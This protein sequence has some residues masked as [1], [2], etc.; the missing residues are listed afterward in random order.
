M[1]YLINRK[2]FILDNIEA[3]LKAAFSPANI[4]ASLS[5]QPL[6]ELQLLLEN[7]GNTAIENLRAFRYQVPP[8]DFQRLCQQNYSDLF[9]LQDHVAAW[10]QDPLWDTLRLDAKAFYAALDKMLQAVQIFLESTGIRGMAAEELLPACYLE[11][12]LSAMA[13]NINL[14]RSRFLSAAADPALQ[15]LL[16]AHFQ[17]SCTRREVRQQELW[18]MEQLMEA[19]LAGLSTSK[20]AD[21]DLFLMHELVKWNFNSPEGYGYCRDKLMAA[22][23][24]KIGRKRRFLLMSWHLKGI[25]QLLCI[26]DQS[27]HPQYPS[28]KDLLIELLQTEIAYAET[29]FSEAE[30]KTPEARLESPT[31]FGASQSTAKFQLQL[32]QRMLA[33]WTQTLI[34]MRIITLGVKGQRRFTEFLADHFTTGDEPIQPDCFRRRYKEKHTAA[35]EKLIRI[36]EQMILIIKHEYM[37]INISAEK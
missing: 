29:G 25:K 8:V 15:D 28:L 37:S 14:L 19:M 33:I 21:N 18:Y 3:L 12:Q 26:P 16:V 2:R 1:T 32:T 9:R 10:Q 27:L 4:E 30:S 23:G 36:L 13:K 31:P 24:E 11:K 35:S 5:T 17:S 20:A 34:T 7:S 6:A 22:F